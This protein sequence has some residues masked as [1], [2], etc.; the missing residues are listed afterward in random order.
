MKK[1]QNIRE[2]YKLQFP[3]D[4]CGDEINPSATFEGIINKLSEIY[5]YLGVPDSI[6]RERVFEKVAEIRGISYDEIYYTWLYK[7]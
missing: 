1:Q 6:V 5:E 7:L 4:E 2:W 3:T